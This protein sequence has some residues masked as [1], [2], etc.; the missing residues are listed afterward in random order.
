MSPCIDVSI[1]AYLPIPPGEG[2][3]HTCLRFNKE[4]IS[5]K[6][7]NLEM[8]LAAAEYRDIRLRPKLNKLCG[9]E[10]AVYCKVGGDECPGQGWWG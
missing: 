7:R 3:V 6:C 9:E 1:K 2:R 8:K 10:K 4:K 5:E